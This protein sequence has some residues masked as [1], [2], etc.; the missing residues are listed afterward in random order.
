MV[1][2]LT[3]AQILA[4]IPAA[5]ARV[6]A[7]RVSGLLAK[8]VMYDR[9]TR[10]FIL[11]R[12]NGMLLGIPTASL[13]ELADA[14][15]TQLAGAV[16]SPSGAVLS[17]PALAA[18]FSIAGIVQASV[19]QKLAARAF[20]VAGGKSTSDAKAAAAR[21]NGA[22]GGRPRVRPMT[23]EEAAKEPRQ[24]QTAASNQSR[25]AA[26][27]LSGPRSIMRDRSSGAKSANAS[28]TLRDGGTSAASKLLGSKTSKGSKSAAG[29]ALSQAR[30]RGRRKD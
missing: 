1:K 9:P 24:M 27:V 6:N 12:S 3:D 5:T 19:G 26:A 28:V 16:L 11:E 4:Q 20:A 14:T 21:A 18:D 30:S 25:A 13:P 22:M 10:R 15:P 17:V 7:D 29:S 2:R 23:E 8:S